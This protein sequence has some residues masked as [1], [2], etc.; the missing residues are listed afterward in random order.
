MGTSNELDT[1]LL[2]PVEPAPP[3]LATVEPPSFPDLDSV[4]DFI[5]EVKIYHELLS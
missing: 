5:F 3:S 1:R 4:D 2:L